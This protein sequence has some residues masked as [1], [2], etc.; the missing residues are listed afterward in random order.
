MIESPVA[1][2][3]ALWPIEITLTNRE[4]MLFRMLLGRSAL[5]GRASVDPSLSY[6]LGRA[7]ARSYPRKRRPLRERS[8]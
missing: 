5:Q 8:T 1:V 7:L 2:G 3:D 4:D 6:S